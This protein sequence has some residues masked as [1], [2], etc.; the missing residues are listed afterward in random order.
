MSTHAEHRANIGYTRLDAKNYLKAKRLKK[1]G[2]RG[3]WLSAAICSTTIIRE[4]LIFSC[5][6]DEHR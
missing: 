6:P 2:V 3:S 4:S 1:Y 5:I